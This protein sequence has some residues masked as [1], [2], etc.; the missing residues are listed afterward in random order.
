M[1][2]APKVRAM[3]IIEE[4]EPTRRGIYGGSVLYGDFGG[5]LNSCIAIR[6]MVVEGRQAHVQADFLAATVPSLQTEVVKQV[7]KDESI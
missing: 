2:G 1:S 6:T 3:E 4:L 5:D 7:Q